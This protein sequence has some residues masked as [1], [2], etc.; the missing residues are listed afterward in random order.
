M[1]RIS[2]SPN[3]PPRVNA[4][5]PTLAWRWLLQSVG[6]VMVGLGLAGVFVPGLP[7]T[8]FVLIA[9]VCYARSSE[10]MLRWLISHRRLGPYAQAFL[11]DY[12][13]PQKVKWTGLAMGWTF[14]GGTALFVA[15]SF[16]MKAL[17]V[18]LGLAQT[19]AILSLK[20]TPKRPQ[21]S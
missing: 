4:A 2:R 15:D 3:A 6:T 18:L 13:V 8:P 21:S 9:A 11:E 14:L 12:S 19:A 20:T 16:A 17:L 5:P 10:R 1:R 7:T